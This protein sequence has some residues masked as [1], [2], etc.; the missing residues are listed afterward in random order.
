MEAS[1]PQQKSLVNAPIRINAFLSTHTHNRSTASDLFIFTLC[2]FL[3][4]AVSKIAEIGGTV[5]V[6]AVD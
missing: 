2:V 5:V 1:I 3:L 4:Y 6:F